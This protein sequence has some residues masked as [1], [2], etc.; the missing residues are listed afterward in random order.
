[1]LTL[2]LSARE[3]AELRFLV[4]LL[5]LVTGTAL[6]GVA[7]GRRA[8]ALPAALLV[9]LSSAGWLRYDRRL[10]GPVL[11]ELLPGHGL[12][13]ADLVAAPGLLLV[14]ALALQALRHASHRSARSAA[15]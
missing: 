13:L 5:A 1:M 7:V 8:L 9:L 10:E 14:G 4:S 3:Q 2:A 11:V 15:R 6:A 12:V